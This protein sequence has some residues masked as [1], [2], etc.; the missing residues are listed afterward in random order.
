MG[1]T[2]WKVV[3][4]TLPGALRA[5]RGSSVP[6]AVLGA[7]AMSKPDI[8]GPATWSLQSYKRRHYT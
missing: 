3:K 5:L 2:G 1:I 7:T 6:S 4:L 8:H